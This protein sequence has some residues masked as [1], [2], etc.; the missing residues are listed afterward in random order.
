MNARGKVPDSERDID[1]DTFDLLVD[2]NYQIILVI[3]ITI[4]IWK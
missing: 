2:I 1:I 4:E 3:T